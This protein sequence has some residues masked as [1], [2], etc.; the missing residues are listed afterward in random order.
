MNPLRPFFR[1][2]RGIWSWIAGSADSRADEV[3]K[4]PTVIRDQF[5]TV[6][7]QKS[8]E[9]AQRYRA[10]SGIVA[11]R[12]AREERIKANGERLASAV[13][14]RSLQ[15]KAPGRD[16]VVNLGFE[17]YKVSTAKQGA[18][19][20]AQERA[21]RVPAAEAGTDPELLRHKEAF[22]A[23]SANENEL[24]EELNR[25]EERLH[26]DIAEDAAAVRTT[27]DALITHKSRLAELKRDIDKIPGM[28]EDMVMD[29][30]GAQEAKRANDVL[31]SLGDDGADD[32]LANL[33]RIRQQAIGE[34][35]VAT[36]MTGSSVSAESEYLEAAGRASIKGEL[37]AMLTFADSEPEPGDNV[38]EH[39]P[40]G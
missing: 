38:A 35:K 27:N 4:N 28:A 19:A 39:L 30:L 14:A 29:V 18:L 7:E 5:R 1:L 2:I 23:F 37:D 21:K 24:L 26:R 25:T 8:R 22:A 12:T 9:Y 16:P 34:A 31:R 36:E 32:T 11:N 6:K 20:K 10:I 17:L 40:R 33:E 13:K 3:M 15:F